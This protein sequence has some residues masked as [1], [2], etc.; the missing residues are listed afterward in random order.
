MTATV[1]NLTFQKDTLGNAVD[2]NRRHCSTEPLV[3]AWSSQFRRLTWGCALDALNLSTC[4]AASQDGVTHLIR[5][6]RTPHS[7]RCRK[8]D[9]QPGHHGNGA[10]SVMAHARG[11]R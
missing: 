1:E 6:S 5:S 8:E 10:A 4:V 11:Q 3:L 2:K 7:T 9:A